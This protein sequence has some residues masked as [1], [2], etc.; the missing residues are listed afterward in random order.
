MTFIGWDQAEHV[1]L[2][3]NVVRNK[4]LVLIGPR[5]SSVSY[6]SRQIFLGPAM[7][8]LMVFFLSLGKWD[9]AI[10]SYVFMVFCGLMVIP[11]YYGVKWLIG[12]PAAWIMVI[13]YTFLPYYLTYTRFLWNPNFQFALL[14][15]LF[16]LMGYYRLT[17]KAW[18]FFFMSFWLGIVFQLHYQFVFAVILIFAYYFVIAREGFKK[19]LL[20]LIGF[21]AALSP[22]MLFELRNHFYLTNTLILFARNYKKIDV[23]GAKNHYYLTLSF[24]FLLGFLALVNKYLEKLKPKINIAL[25]SCLALVLFFFSSKI[26]FD[27]PETPFWA[28]APYWNYQAE[29]KIYEIV[30]NEGLKDFNVTNQLYDALAMIQK[31]M[32]MRDN[33]VI[34]Y[35]DYWNNKYLFVVDKAGKKDYME[36]PGYEVKYFRPYKLL[37]T[38][39]INDHYNMYLVERLPKPVKKTPSTSF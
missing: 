27:R 34:N 38:W 6:A 17:K 15:I 28:P 26:T 5:V 36:N 25:I 30:K 33:I 8:Y 29:V 32:M 22:L 18:V 12:K 3:L 19:F 14:P 31:Y 1:I 4:E 7:T 10:T 24:V 11:L 23:L 13:I 16:F 9:P 21:S 37:K 39:K 2:A 35:D 20:F